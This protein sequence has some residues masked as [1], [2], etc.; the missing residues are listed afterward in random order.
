MPRPEYQ[1]HTHQ[2]NLNMINLTTLSINDCG[3]FVALTTR[4]PLSAKV[5][6]TSP[7]SGGGSVGTVRACGLKPRSLFLFVNGSDY[8]A[9]YGKITDDKFSR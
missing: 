7:T 1:D 3:G 2:I 9:L 6:T 4:H 8:I 5:G